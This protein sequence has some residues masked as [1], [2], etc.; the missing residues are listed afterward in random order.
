MNFFK[1]PVFSSFQKIL[2][3]EMKH[4][5][6]LGVGGKKRQGKPITV[7]EEATMG[8]K[9]LWVPLSSSTSGCNGILKSDEVEEAKKLATSEEYCLGHTGVEGLVFKSPEVLSW[10][11]EKA[12]WVPLSSSTCGCNGIFKWNTLY[13]TKWSAG[14]I[15]AVSHR[16]NVQP[17]LQCVRSFF[18]WPDKTSRQ[19]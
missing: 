8:E 9:A 10:T 7:E 18:S 6:P 12:L 16:T 4:L 11:K 15:I 14:Q 1:D 2:D 13:P 19:K 17:Y 3:S 5:S